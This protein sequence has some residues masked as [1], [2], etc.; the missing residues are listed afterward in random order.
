MTETKGFARGIYIAKMP[1]PN[2]FPFFWQQLYGNLFNDV[3]FHFYLQKCR[4]KKQS[5][6]K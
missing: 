4:K 5:I 3:G 6:R 1:T 2:L